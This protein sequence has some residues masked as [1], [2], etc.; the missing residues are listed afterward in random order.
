MTRI[1]RPC[2]TQ[3][4]VNVIY[5]EAPEK[6]LKVGD[7]AERLGYKRTTTSPVYDFIHA[8]LL[9]K[10]EFNNSYRVREAELNRFIRENE[11]KDM[12]KVLKDARAKNK[13]L[14]DM[15]ENMEG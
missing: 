9:K 7:V 11:G 2:T 3:K 8:G 14:P 15:G 5:Q 12:N 10:L 6:L 4:V 1:K 13:I